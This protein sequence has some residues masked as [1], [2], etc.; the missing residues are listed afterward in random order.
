MQFQYLAPELYLQQ[1]LK[2]GKRIDNRKAN[3]ARNLNAT[4]QC[5]DDS[6]SSSMVSLGQTIVVTK[7]KAE[8]Q[9]IA[10]SFEIIV[11]HSGVSNEKGKGTED[12]ALEM[13]LTSIF[14]LFGNISPLKLCT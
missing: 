8:P 12:P 10:P 14:V 11:F 3:E 5:L 4:I 9:P 1:Y 13:T 6:E 2:S 7:I